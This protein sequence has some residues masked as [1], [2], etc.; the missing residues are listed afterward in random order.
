MPRGTRRWGT[1]QHHHSHM[2]TTWFLLSQP[3][4]TARRIKG[5]SG[6]LRESL[7]SGRVGT[8]RGLHCIADPLLPVLR[9]PWVSWAPPFQPMALGSCRGSL[10]ESPELFRILHTTTSPPAP[11]A[12]K[13]RSSTEDA[14]WCQNVCVGSAWGAP[15]E[16][17]D[18]LCLTSH[19]QWPPWTAAASGCSSC[20][21]ALAG[22]SLPGVREGLVHA[23]L[24]ASAELVLSGTVLPGCHLTPLVQQE[25]EELDLCWVDA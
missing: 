11:A 5:D 2:P 1:F 15:L 6:K 25:A 13:A 17:F 3:D 22:G 4:Q 9:G 12:G 14:R 7:S 21:G 19:P 20:G 16:A 18:G 8:H 23:L 10:L 24:P